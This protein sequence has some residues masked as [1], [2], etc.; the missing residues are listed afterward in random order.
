MPK[1]MHLVLGLS[2]LNTRKKKPKITKKR[3][4][5]LIEQHRVYNKR[6]K[7]TNNR[8][9]MMSFDDFLKRQFGQ[10]KY[11]PKNTGTYQPSNWIVEKTI[12]SHVQKDMS[13]YQHACSKPNDDYKRE[14]SSQYVIGQAYNESG[15]QVLTKR[16]SN[17]PSTGKRR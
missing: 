2:S 11:K 4:T 12:P 7:Q 5:E 14:I 17:D 8:S 15:L 16:E 13:E 3:M 1:G 10:M 9:M 6:M